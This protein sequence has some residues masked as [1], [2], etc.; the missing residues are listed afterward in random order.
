M[1]GD[2]YDSTWEDV[3]KPYLNKINEKNLYEKFISLMTEIYNGRQYLGKKYTYNESKY[4]AAILYI[5][6]HIEDKENLKL[7]DVEN[8]W[9][10]V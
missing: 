1:H 10:V 9:S 8:I 7:E 2:I 5:Y 4:Y 6:F 3:L